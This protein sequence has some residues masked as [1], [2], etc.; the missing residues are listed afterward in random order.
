M[1]QDRKI[2][3][4]IW[5]LEHFNVY[6]QTDRTKFERL[7]NF[8]VRKADMEICDGITLTWSLEYLALYLFDGKGYC[9]VVPALHLGVSELTKIL[10]AQPWVYL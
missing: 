9:K 7:Q 8:Y 2:A 3:K 4:A 10:K 1:T 6:R 5:D